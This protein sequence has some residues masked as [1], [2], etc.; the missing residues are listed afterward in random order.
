MESL[1]AQTE[2]HQLEVE[3]QLVTH[4]RLSHNTAGKAAYDFLAKYIDGN[5][6]R[7]I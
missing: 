2:N 6:C 4:W 1:V 5:S 7:R 3:L